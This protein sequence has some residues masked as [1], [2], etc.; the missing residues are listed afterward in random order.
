MNDFHK[1]TENHYRRRTACNADSACKM[2]YP[3]FA[4]GRSDNLC[5]PQ[6][7]GQKLADLVTL[8]A[9]FTGEICVGGREI[10]PHTVLYLSLEDTFNRLQK[11]LL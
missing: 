4:T 6:Q 3:R 10:E 1:I 2:D 11:R 5:R 9:D 8:L 7:G